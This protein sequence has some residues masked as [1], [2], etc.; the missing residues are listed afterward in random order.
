MSNVAHKSCTKCS[1][2]LPLDAF[3]KCGRNK[4]GHGS[5]CL[6]CHR[7]VSA[8][9]VSNNRDKRLESSRSYYSRNADAHNERV[10]SW[11]KQHPEKVKEIRAR[12]RQNNA[13][14]AKEY[15]KRYGYGQQQSLRALYPD[16]YRARNKVNN[17][18]A[19]GKLPRASTFSCV[20]CGGPAKD[21]HHHKGYAPEFWLD[22][23]PVCRA[24]HRDVEPDHDYYSQLNQS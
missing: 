10:K 16:R 1:R 21:Y 17:A 2:T 19:G 11:A 20:N 18:V 12:S 22:V 15:R 9:Y 7:K 13:Q 6:E 4:D 5:R 14:S 3:V 23:V 8:N 24:C